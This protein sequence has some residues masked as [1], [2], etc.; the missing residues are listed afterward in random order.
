MAC[1][2]ARRIYCM[3]GGRNDE[4]GEQIVTG[5]HPILA[6]AERQALISDASYGSCQPTYAYCTW[7]GRLPYSSFMFFRECPYTPVESPK[8]GI[9]YDTDMIELTIT[10]EMA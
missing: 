2:G 1:I 10:D 5:D 8:E 6:T 7:A 4:L 9:K 3:D